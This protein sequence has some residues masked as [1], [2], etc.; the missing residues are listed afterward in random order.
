[1]KKIVFF[2]ADNDPADLYPFTLTRKA[3]DIRSGILTLR[4][5]WEKALGLPS[6]DAQ[7]EATSGKHLTSVF[8]S[9]T[10]A[11]DPDEDAIGINARLVPTLAL[12]VLI[13]KLK[14]GQSIKT[15]EEKITAFRICDRA[16]LKKKA[17]PDIEADAVHFLQYPWDIFSFNKA[18]IIFDFELITQGRKSIPIDKTN[19]VSSSKR[20]F[21]EKGAVVKHCIINADEGPVYI[22][23][24]ALVMEGS[25]LRGPIA[26]GENA[27]VKMGARIYGAT[28][29]GPGCTV[30]G[31]VKNSVLF[32]NSN[33]AHDGYLGDSVIGEW[34]NL[35]AGT[36]NSNLKNTA[37][38]IDVH[39][40]HKKIA[41]G[42]KCGVL[43]GDFSRTAINTSVNTG[44][45]IGVSANVFGSGLTPK[46]IPSFSWGY[47]G[48]ARYKLEKALMDA[49]RWKAL[50]GA[51][52]TKEET[53][54]FKNIYK[55][56]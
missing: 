11:F 53:E 8:D 41:A 36:S 30:G 52:L 14:P 1:M 7:R 35:G 10:I 20:I 18:A 24:N 45:V 47:D 38:N 32:A 54:I 29:I 27:V 4:Q 3:Q 22:G 25:C 40:P 49:Q 5:K 13:K 2:Q 23:K 39:L 55:K 42:L 43:M 31:E 9:E 56:R 44:T 48:K 33:K 21:I 16:G 26:I 6:I 12:V 50:K 19:A 34:C 51:Q 28:T 17:Y 37:G 15:R 46:Y